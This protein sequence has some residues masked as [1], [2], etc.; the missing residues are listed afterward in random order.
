[1]VVNLAKPT[2]CG[3]APTHPPCAAEQLRVVWVAFP[4][5]FGSVGV[6]PLGVKR[7]RPNA[8]G[9]AGSDR[10]C[11]W[12]PPPALRAL[13]WL[14]GSP[15]ASRRLSPAAAARQPPPLQRRHRACCSRWRGFGGCAALRGRE[16]PL[17]AARPRAPP[18]PPLPRRRLPR[19][20]PLRRA[21]SSRVGSLAV[22]FPRCAAVR[23]A[24][25]P[26]FN[27]FLAMSE[28]VRTFAA[29]LLTN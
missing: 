9:V 19:A 17:A 7:L 25:G 22:R 11:G 16:G 3:R 26:R 23:P 27:F 12:V 2:K 18:W 28:K 20:R 1:M 5:G 4:L 14:C 15:G 29:E 6:G 21:P 8:F 13:C 24:F 10:A